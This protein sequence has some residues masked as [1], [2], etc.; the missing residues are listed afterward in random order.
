MMAPRIKQ[1][2]EPLPENL[3]DGS[4]LGEE[5][6]DLRN[7]SGETNNLHGVGNGEANRFELEAKKR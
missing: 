5:V 7:D 6:Y 2:K 3:N 1:A 4:L